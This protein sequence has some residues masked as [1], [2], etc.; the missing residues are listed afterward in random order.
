MFKRDEIFLHIMRALTKFLLLF[1]LSFSCLGLVPTNSK[2]LFIEDQSYKDKSFQLFKKELVMAIKNKNI[3]FI[4]DIVSKNVVFSFGYGPEYKNDPIGTFLRFYKLDKQ[5]DKTEFW[6]NLSKIISL[7][8]IFKIEGLYEC[9]YI[10]SDWPS[11]LDYYD[12]VVSIKKDAKI[13]TEP[14]KNASVV[15]LAD[16]EILK[17]IPPSM[18]NSWFIVKIDGNK[19]GY[20]HE[21]EAHSPIGYRASFKKVKE[22]WFLE[23]FIAGD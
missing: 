18:K 8:C 9:P 22:K 20:I 13:V 19:T 21:S 2:K 1:S 6:K 5:H 7:G 3:A 12:Y 15:R 10:I 17:L 16:F 11:D 4:R 23:S 14:S